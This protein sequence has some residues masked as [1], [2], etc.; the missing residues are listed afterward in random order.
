MKLHPARRERSRL[1][2]AKIRDL[3]LLIG[4]NREGPVV[5]STPGCQ[6]GEVALHDSNRHTRRTKMGR[7]RTA[8]ESRPSSELI[9]SGIVIS[10]VGP[11]PYL[12]V[13]PG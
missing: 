4:W 6:A 13:I 8:N 1:S 2:E 3:H 12:A 9:R 7:T 5:F 10:M 11:Y